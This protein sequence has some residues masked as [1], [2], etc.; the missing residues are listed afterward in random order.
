MEGREDAR[1]DNLGGEDGKTDVQ[2]SF[3]CKGWSDVDKTIPASIAKI[4]DVESTDV[5]S[6]GRRVPPRAPP[7]H[8]KS[9]PVSQGS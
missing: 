3:I 4:S 1:Q 7:R 6:Y 5:L 9:Y 8:A 2:L